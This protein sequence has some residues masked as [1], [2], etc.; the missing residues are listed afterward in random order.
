MRRNL[1][2]IF[3]AI[4]AMTILWACGNKQQVIT[5][6]DPLADYE[7]SVVR[8]DFDMSRAVFEGLTLPADGKKFR[9]RATLDNTEGK[10]YYYKIFYQN[11]SYAFADG[12]S[13]DEEN[14]Y[15]SWQDCTIGFKAASGNVIEDTFRI[16]GNPRN[17]MLYYG[18]PFP[19]HA[20]EDEVDNMIARIESDTAWLGHLKR[21]S[22]QEYV[23][24][25][26]LKYRDAIW[27]LS[28]D[29]GS[30]GEMVN[31]RERRNPRVGSYE[32]MLVVADSAALSQIPDYIRNISLQRDSHYVNPLAYF[33]NGE[34]SKLRGVHVRMG[35]KTLKATAHYDLDRG[36]FV[37]MLHYPF[38]R[39]LYRGNKNVGDGDSLYR[40]AQFEQYFH[41]IAQDRYVP[42]IRKSANVHGSEYTLQDYV[43]HST[44]AAWQRDSIHPVITS[45]PG[46][47]VACR[48]HS[49]V[50]VN[51]GNKD[52]HPRKESVG[53][54]SRVGF[55]Y[56]RFI[57]KIKFAPLLNKN[58]AYNGLT[59]AAW[60]IYESDLPWNSRR[61]SGTGY[62]VSERDNGKV[63][64]RKGT[65]SY[66]EIDIEMVK[67]S[68]YW[69]GE[70]PPKNYKPLGSNNIVLA[71]TNWDLA[72]NDNGYVTKKHLRFQRKHGRQRFTYNR[73]YTNYR[74]LTSK[75]E[76][77]ND[78][79]LQPYYYVIEWTPKSIAWYVG[80][81]M[82]H[83][84]MVSYMDDSFTAIPNNQMLPIVTQE[85]HY[86][87]FW[88][89]QVFEQGSIPYPT[90]D[91]AGT[92]Y[93]ITVE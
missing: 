81:D 76:V 15:G 57:F 6:F 32:F 82:E 22:E 71:A 60:L 27:V 88:P 20:N 68:K 42:Q 1:S 43:S 38:R 33:R 16:V 12:D 52:G 5:S 54:R 62:V 17:E 46:R 59:N 86:S 37:D 74:A 90:E 83:L 92:I 31:R 91:A 75:V 19:A 45:Q 21:K 41:F 84:R 80:R 61:R 11:S 28:H 29:D 44:I 72:C 51:P 64:D 53:V 30:E 70:E 36:V 8:M 14:F 2:F 79:F 34:G 13:H 66:S 39:E 93:E 73:W 24:L 7:D 89:P 85:Y 58:G 18:R 47:T 65:T 25:E 4:M 67:T 10:T 69:P 48:N 56:G 87:E 77:S 49:I 9:F 35:A 78:I 3:F 50:I 55:T 40:Y 63:A 26:D 23:E